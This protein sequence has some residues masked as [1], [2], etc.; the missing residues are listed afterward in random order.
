VAT[1]VLD[2]DTSLNLDTDF[3]FT[4]GG[5]AGSAYVD[6]NRNNSFDS[7]EP[8]LSGVAITLAGGG[9][10]NTNVDGS[11]SFGG[12]DA[13]DY[14][15]SAPAVASGHDLWTASPLSVS[16]AP[17][18]L[19]TNVNFGYVDGSISG[20]AYVD[21]NSNDTKDPGETGLGNVL[22]SLTGTPGG[23]VL[24]NA[25]GSYLFGGLL[26]GPFSVAAPSSVDTYTLTT[27]SPLT[28]AVNVGQNVTDVNFGYESAAA[29]IPAEF[30]SKASVKSVLDP[31]TGR[32][33][34]NGGL[35][36]FVHT[37]QGQSIQA[38]INT[39]EDRN[40]DG[41][42]IIGV[43][44]K[45]QIGQLG[46]NV[47]ENLVIDRVFPKPFGLFA[48]SVTVHDP[49]P[50]DDVPTGRITAAAS[51]SVDPAQLGIYVMD[52]H[53]DDSAVAGWKVEGN[54]RY[55]RNV[56]AREN[57]VGVWF[58]G[59]NNT[60]HNGVAEANSG[61]G[62]LIQGNSNV[63]TDTDVMDNGGHGI[64][65][66]GDS[67]QILKADVGEA[68][69]GNQLDGINVTGSSTVLSE[70]D[71]F[72][73]GGDGIRVTGNGSQLLKNRVGDKNKGNGGDGI[74]LA[75]SESQLQENLV[76][77]N[78]GDG[79]EVSGG[80]ADSP[81]VLK[82]NKSGDKTKG[83][84][85]NGILVAGTGNGTANP[86]EI[87]ENTVK[88]NGLVG[89]QVTGA[90]HQ[91]KKNT[92]GGSASGETNIGCEYLAATGNFNATGNKANGTTVAGSNNSPF[93]TSCVGP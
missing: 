93:P 73:N 14:A 15:V 26:A 20:Y 81:N 36:V 89:V 86:I 58:V 21:A 22:I 12:L 41:Y 50:G 1:V 85:G 19:R 10:V 88:S 56:E 52:V 61:A 25:D 33:P 29:Q 45:E 64:Q 46:G 71:A 57:G 48:C 59:N 51:V 13:G 55:L 27:P 60:M 34:N 63:V 92:S 66:V 80:T 28:P 67:N 77:A 70:N 23:D 16:L 65:V 6:V 7:G 17:G 30:C 82:R 18:E 40:G 38:A 42:I 5:I 2:T 4:L 90:G 74:H 76:Y 69:L 72:H 47:T 35:D 68:G 11:Y 37:V 44:A 3:G 87:D 39:A 54:K 79:I 91:L 32:F 75:G 62:L 84:G 78:A 31:A 53:A 83:N 8:P 49:M 24:T 9:T 43:S